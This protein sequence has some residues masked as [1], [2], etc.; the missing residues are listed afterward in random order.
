[1]T[2]P[3]TRD[4]VPRGFDDA[5]ADYDLMV[6]LNPGYRRHLRA[7]A[8]AVVS[9]VTTATPVLLDLGCGSGL[10]TR[11]LLAAA[12]RRGMRPTIVGVDASAAML[13]QAQRRTWPAGVTF[14][15][16]KAEDLASLDLPPAD[17]V[18]ACYLLRNTPALDATLAEIHRALKPGAPFVAEDYSVRGSR[19]GQRRWHLVNRGIVIPLAHVL[20]GDAELYEYLHRSVDDF[21]TMP[22]LAERLHAAGFTDVASRT[23][24]GWQ[25]DILHLIRATA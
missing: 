12:R 10:S 16:C 9:R 20:T 17:G 23:V 8:E 21:A 7:A 18:L 1:M 4:D 13:A 24:D 11:E 5:A 6:A 22:E 25:R 2:A 19:S 14:R 3:L 15:H